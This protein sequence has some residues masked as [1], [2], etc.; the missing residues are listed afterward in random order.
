M[1]KIKKD[2]HEI[3]DRE[4]EAWDNQDAELL[5]SI[6]HPDMVWPWPVN[7]NDHDPIKWVLIQ[8][9]FDKNRWIKNWNN[10]FNAYKLSHN[11]R[12]T[13]KILIS[14]ERDAAFAVVDID[15]LWINKITRKPFHWKGRVSKT[16]VKLTDGWKLIMHT[17]VLNYEI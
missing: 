5:C 12:N 7:S 8:G 6:F 17:G 10:L 13:V 15:T 1:E 16:Y 9:R 3:I 2:I 14:D 4:T 11:K